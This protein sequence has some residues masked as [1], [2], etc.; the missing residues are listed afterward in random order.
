MEENLS[1][2]EKKGRST[3]EK[4]YLLVMGFSIYFSIIALSAF[5]AGWV[6]LITDDE[7]FDLIGGEAGLTSSMASYGGSEIKVWDGQMYMIEDDYKYTVY[8]DK[9]TVDR[10]FIVLKYKILNKTIYWEQEH[11]ET[12]QSESN[13]NEEVAMV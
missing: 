4:A 8:T 7:V 12:L 11:P 10:L 6:T 13:I 9:D 2:E 3:F 5:H 1:S